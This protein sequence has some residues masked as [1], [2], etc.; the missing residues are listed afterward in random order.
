MGKEIANRQTVRQMR[1][2]FG[3]AG[4]QGPETLPQQRASLP[5]FA[6]CNLQF[7]IC[8]LLFLLVSLVLVAPAAAQMPPV[9]PTPLRP[10]A[11]VP[12]APL[13]HPDPLLYVRFNG[14]PGLKITFY[15]GAATGRTLEVPCTVALRPGYRYRLK[16]N[17]FAKRPKEYLTPTLEVRGALQLAPTIKASTYPATINFS[18]DDIE[19]ALSSILVTKVVLLEDPEKAIPVAASVD[20]PLETHLLPGRDPLVEARERGRPFVVMHV[21]D[22]AAS[23]VELARQGIPGTILLPGEKALPAP[24]CPPWVP[25]TC[26]PLFDPRL[27]PRP[28]TEQ[29]ICDGGDR[30]LPAGLGPDG[31]LRGLDPSDTVAIYTDSK[32]WRRLAISNCV[33]ILVPRFVLIWSE[34]A[35]ASEVIQVALR[36]TEVVHVQEQINGQI[37]SLQAQ[38]NERL[39]SV[40]RTQRLTSTQFIQP[41]PVVTAKVLGVEITTQLEQTK[42]VTGKCAKL[43]PEPPDRPLCLIKWPDKCATLEGDIVTFFLKYTNQGGQVMTDIVVTDSLASRFEYVPGSSRAD[44]SVT[45]TTQENEAGSLVLRWQVNGPLLPG[46]SGVV[47]FQVRVR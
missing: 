4:W 39:V 7:A 27:G 28:Q 33:C 15:R 24:A 43:T 34:I 2:T 8:N 12:F 29:C 26:A 11:P 36:G 14:P 10:P 1:E 13:P 18:E 45:F 21:G 46:Q 23:E 20:D 16:V 37:T 42:D 5:Q 32:G 38:Q 19:R 9:P 44:R 30:G 6:I 41:G 35:P 47:S 22:Y 17:G 31:E 25:W 40:L 3:R